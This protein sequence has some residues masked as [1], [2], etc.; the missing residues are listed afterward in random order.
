[1]KAMYKLGRARTTL[2][3]LNTWPVVVSRSPPASQGGPGQVPECTVRW[4]HLYLGVGEPHICN[5]C[6]MNRPSEALTK[7]VLDSRL[8]SSLQHRG[9]I[10]IFGQLLHSSV[11][12]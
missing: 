8:N 12:L 5:V 10:L 4:R 6:E 2:T 11:I 1:M 7:L 9:Q 3:V